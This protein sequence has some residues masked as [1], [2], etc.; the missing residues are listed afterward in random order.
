MRAE[1]ADVLARLDADDGVRVVLTGAGPA[2]CAGVDLKET[3]PP[4]RGR[5]SPTLSP[6]R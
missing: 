4:G 5:A 2:F 6:R 1:L 3:V